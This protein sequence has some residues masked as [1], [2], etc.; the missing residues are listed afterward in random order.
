MLILILILMHK[1]F[2]FALRSADLR[3]HVEK[4]GNVAEKRSAQVG[5][6]GSEK[7]L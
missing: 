7:D 5:V 1:Y 2:N 4:R 3:C 6:D